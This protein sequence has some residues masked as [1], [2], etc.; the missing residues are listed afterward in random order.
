MQLQSPTRS[1]GDDYAFVRGA[2]AQKS[3]AIVAAKRSNITP[4][5]ESTRSERSHWKTAAPINSSTRINPIMGRMSSMLK[6]EPAGA[7][8]GSFVVYVRSVSSGSIEREH[9]SSIMF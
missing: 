9:L 5:N 8:C 3:N 2:I 7:S 6:R 1:E 4:T